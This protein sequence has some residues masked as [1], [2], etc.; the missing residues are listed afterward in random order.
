MDWKKKEYWL[1]LCLIGL[2]TIYGYLIRNQTIA[3]TEEIDLAAI[4]VEVGDWV[5][6]QFLFDNNVLDELKAD[7]TLFRRYSN[8]QGAEVWL[9][10][11]YWADQK[12]G[13]Q[14]HSPLHCLPGSGWNILSKELV[15]L[16]VGTDGNGVDHGEPVNFAVISNGKEQSSMLFWYETR[17][18]VISRELS[19]KLDLAKN[20]LL[21]KP[22]D[23]AFIRVTSPVH[24]QS[25]SGT[26][27]ELREFLGVM[28][29]QVSQV[30]PFE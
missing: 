20:S 11:G 8:S 22:T 15:S 2:T 6:E 21:R 26:L 28:K 9:F 27:E 1:V 14:P 19:V 23:A 5:G 7:Q 17:S 18:G 3:A 24:L 16:Q 4:P 12:Y 13:A 25:K 30:L 10:I 29:P